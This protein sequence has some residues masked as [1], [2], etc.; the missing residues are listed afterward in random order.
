MSNLFKKLN[1]RLPRLEESK[2]DTY[3]KNLD[4]DRVSHIK[5]IGNLQGIYEKELNQTSSNDLRLY[6]FALN[7]KQMHLKL[8]EIEDKS[9]NFITEKIKKNNHTLQ[10][11][12]TLSCYQLPINNT[13]KTYDRIIEEI[14]KLSYFRK[15]I[16]TYMDKEIYNKNWQAVKGFYI[17]IAKLVYRIYNYET[18][19]RKLIIV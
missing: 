10:S 16:I 4:I 8:T 13:N 3:F 17:A 19:L 6:T 18:I 14:D 1:S 7:I 12:F 11:H 15:R 9:L 5:F 2:K